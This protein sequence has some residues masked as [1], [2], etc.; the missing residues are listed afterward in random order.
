M[1]EC[2]QEIG[3]L[4]SMNTCRKVPLQ[5]NFFRLRHFALTTL[6]LIFRR[7][8]SKANALNKCIMSNL[9]CLLNTLSRLEIVEFDG[10]I[11]LFVANLG[12]VVFASRPPY[13]LGSSTPAA[14]DV[15]LDLDHKNSNHSRSFMKTEILKRELRY[16]FQGFFVW[17][18]MLKYT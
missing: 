9:F 10:C 17:L 16:T 4:Q 13:S 2:T 15:T 5:G 7:G 11:N 12:S 14:R 6:S 3:Y 1:T 8:I 18:K